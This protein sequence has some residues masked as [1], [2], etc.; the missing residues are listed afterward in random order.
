MHPPEIS[1]AP[2]AL[3]PEQKNGPDCSRP[4][5]L[6]RPFNAIP[7]CQVLKE[8]AQVLS[9]AQDSFVALIALHAAS[10]TQAAS[11]A[12]KARAKEA[13]WQQ[14]IARLEERVARFQQDSE[15]LD[16]LI[17]AARKLEE[18]LAQQIQANAQLQNNSI[19]LEDA[20]HDLQASQEHSEHLQRQY[21]L[22]QHEMQQLKSVNRVLLT[23][24]SALEKDLAHVKYDARTRSSIAK[25]PKLDAQELLDVKLRRENATLRTKENMAQ[26]T[27]G[28]RTENELAAGKL[29]AA[30]TRI[31]Q[32]DEEIKELKGYCKALHADL[33][34][35]ASALGVA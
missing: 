34:G 28:S 12:D 15:H 26:E 19:Q 8:V 27:A 20:R 5:H 1:L 13:H 4:Q 10:T 2:P 11:E 18:Q 9:Q 14:D 33:E 25:D 24:I 23:D 29:E 16:I 35:Q 22:T 32:Q 3:S 6:Q 31:R 21:E 7:N 17:P 30:L